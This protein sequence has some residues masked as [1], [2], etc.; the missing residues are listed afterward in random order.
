MVHI[1]LKLEHFFREII[2]TRNFHEEIDYT[3]K[4]FTF[5]LPLLSSDFVEVELSRLSTT[6]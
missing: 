1:L 5:T 4:K 3:V 6:F 2:F